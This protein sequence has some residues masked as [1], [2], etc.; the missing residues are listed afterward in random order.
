MG[1]NAT[2]ISD[3]ESITTSTKWKYREGTTKLFLSVLRHFLGTELRSL[4]SSSVYCLNLAVFI[5]DETCCIKKWYGDNC[6]SCAG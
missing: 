5:V 4:L 3:K 1:I 6:L 2:Y